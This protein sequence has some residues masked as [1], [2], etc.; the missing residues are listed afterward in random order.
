M[1]MRKRGCVRPGAERFGVCNRQITFPANLSQWAS[2]GDDEIKKVRLFSAICLSAKPDICAERWVRCPVSDRIKHTVP[3][4]FFF[5]CFF[6]NSPPLF[7]KNIIRIIVNFG[8]LYVFSRVKISDDRSRNMPGCSGSQCVLVAPW[9]IAPSG[10][11]LGWLSLGLFTFK[12]QR[13]VRKLK[14]PSGAHVNVNSRGREAHSVTHRETLKWQL[15]Q[16]SVLDYIED[17]RISVILLPISHPLVLSVAQFLS[18]STIFKYPIYKLW[19]KEILY[20]INKTDPSNNK[21]SLIKLALF[22]LNHPCLLV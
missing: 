9:I 7:S 13:I 6:Q 20:F 5:F 3:L 12:S 16:N 22:K 19:I 21:K 11:P 18:N 14:R 4:L 15:I 17:V 2:D 10:D 1:C 8:A